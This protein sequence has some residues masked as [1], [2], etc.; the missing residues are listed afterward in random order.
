MLDTRYR[1]ADADPVVRSLSFDSPR[2]PGDTEGS[3]LRRFPRLEG[4][5][6]SSQGLNMTTI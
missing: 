5:I 3:L 6:V 1:R 2:D 4:R